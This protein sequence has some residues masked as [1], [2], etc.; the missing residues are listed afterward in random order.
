MFY[1]YIQSLKPRTCSSLV[2]ILLTCVYPE[3][4]AMEFAHVEVEADDGEHEDGEEE[5]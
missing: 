3:A 2:L 5:Q 4:G 1:Q